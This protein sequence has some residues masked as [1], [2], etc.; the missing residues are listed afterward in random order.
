[1]L[2]LADCTEYRQAVEAR[3]PGVVHGAAALL[4]LLVGSALLWA[5]LTRA[6]LVVRAAGRVRPVGA[7]TRV[8]NTGRGDLLS[9]GAGARVAEGNF[10]P[11]DTVRKGDVLIR[12]CTE[13]LD[14]DLA[15]QARAV[16][17]G[18]EELAN[19]ARL[20]RL[21][22]AQFE[23]ARARAEAELAQAREE[24]RQARARQGPD[25][26]LAELELA[27]ARD[28]EE[29]LRRLAERRSAAEAD[30]VKAAA[31]S[32][33]ARERLARARLPVDEGRVEVL[34]RAL[35]LVETEFAVRREE[36]GM[37]RAA[38]AGEL[39]AARAELA[40]LELERRQAVLRAPVDGVV[41]AGDVKVGDLLESGKAVAEIAGQTGFRFEMAVPS[42]EVAHLRV[43]MPA[44][45]RLDALDPQT[46]G[47][48]VGTV[49]YIAP[50]STV[51]EGQQA[52]SYVVRIDLDGDEVGVGGA[53][54]R[55]KLGMAGQAE[56]VTGQEGLLGLLLKRIR[57]T[58]SLG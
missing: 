19:L 50:D 56:V 27:A 41:T 3:P 33:E 38:R 31:R 45:V 28:E 12:L 22:A 17:A 14:G 53:R 16:R 44:R 23:A 47:T 18:E 2:D 8:F 5:A 25:T 43:G 36:L 42:E 34:R 55:V 1:M 10:R 21:T 26:R 49:S 24:V 6:D 48:A 32:G 37:K 54:G 11:G 46:Y 40:K 35:A 52:A 51:P 15:R 9:A 30:V 7:T 20:E 13:R 58:V 4:A 29:R 57:Q 39:E